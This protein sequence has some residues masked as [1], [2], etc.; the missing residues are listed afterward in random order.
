MYTIVYKPSK[1]KTVLLIMVSLLA[2][3][4]LYQILKYYLV[5]YLI[6]TGVV[7]SACVGVVVRAVGVFLMY[8]GTYRFLAADMEKN[9][10]DYLLQ[11]M[12]TTLLRL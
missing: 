9:E 11:G 10:N 2:V 5:H 12:H 4:S 3:V 7:V 8:P 6:V 1:A